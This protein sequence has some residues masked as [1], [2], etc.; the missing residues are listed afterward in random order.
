MRGKG[1]V[2][3][4]G[5]FMS[6]RRF[7]RAGLWRLGRGSE[8][9]FRVDERG[10]PGNDGGERLG[11]EREGHGCCG[12]LVVSGLPGPEIRFYFSY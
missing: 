2:V 11:R 5:M 12:V 9:G 4:S 3:P 8:G 6:A 7:V 10:V 1:S